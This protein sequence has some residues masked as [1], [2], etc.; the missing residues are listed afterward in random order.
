MLNPFLDTEPTL[1][2]LL[3]DTYTHT[4]TSIAYVKLL[5]LHALLLEQ[6]L[7]DEVQV[8]Y[9]IWHLLYIQRAI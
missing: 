4:H 7:S 2:N 9:M 8:Q 5:T 3:Y 6:T 1:S